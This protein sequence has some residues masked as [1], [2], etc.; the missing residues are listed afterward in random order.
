VTETRRYLSPKRD[1]RAAATRGAILGAFAEQLSE[2]GRD[3]LSPSE[4][5]LRAGVSLRTVHVHFPNEESQIAAL[6]EWFEEHFHLDDIA[7]AA[8]PNDLARYYCDIHARALASPLSRA[9][10]E[11]GTRP[12][13]HVEASRT[14]CVPQSWRTALHRTN[15]RPAKLGTPLAPTN[16]TKPQ[17]LPVEGL[18]RGGGIRTP[19]P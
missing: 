15:L 12:R 10:A 13:E 6:G 16:P 11:V 5:A 8:G 4:A 7:G 3:K 2:P 1:A 17:D 14:A 18:S 9:V 19:D